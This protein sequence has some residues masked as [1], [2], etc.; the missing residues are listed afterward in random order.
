MLADETQ[1]LT[2]IR[3][4]AHFVLQ[5]QTCKAAIQHFDIQV[6][7]QTQTTEVTQLKGNYALPLQDA[8]GTKFLPNMDVERTILAWRV[9]CSPNWTWPGKVSIKTVYEL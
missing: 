4:T 6:G 9:L 7:N 2:S 1:G 3:G 5:H 8:V